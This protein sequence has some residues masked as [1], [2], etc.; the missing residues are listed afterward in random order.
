MAEDQAA[1][2]SRG[3]VFAAA[4]SAYLQPPTSFPGRVQRRSTGMLSVLA[5]AGRSRE[6]LQ[7]LNRSGAAAI[8]VGA[9]ER[10]KKR[11]EGLRPPLRAGEPTDKIRRCCGM[12]GANR[13][14]PSTGGLHYGEFASDLTL[15]RPVLPTICLRPWWL[16]PD[17]ALH[18]L[19]PAAAIRQV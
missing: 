11:C 18:L 10:K 13:Q 19:L 9:G 4:A 8:R 7:R 3:E 5:H 15:L 1:T 6:G 12:R 2:H 17:L 14:G 16:Q